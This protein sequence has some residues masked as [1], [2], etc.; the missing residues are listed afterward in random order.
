[1]NINERYVHMT[2]IKIEVEEKIAGKNRKYKRKILYL[3][4]DYC[5]NE[6]TCPENTKIR[7]LKK[8]NHFCSKSCSTNSLKNGLLRNK[9]E[10]TLINK[11][12][13]KGYVTAFDFQDKS[14]KSCIDKYGV[15]HGMKV[16]KIKNKLKQVC[17]EKYGK[18]TF[19]GSD[20]WRSKVD[21]K[22]IARKAWLT[23]IKNGSCSKS[24]TEEKLYQLLC[25][26]FGVDDVVRQVYI[27]RQWIDFYIKSLDLYLQL[28]GVYWHGLNRNISEIKNSS[29]RQDKKIYQNYVRDQKLNSYMKSKGLKMIRITDEL[30]N[31]SCK[32]DIINLLGGK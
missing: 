16:E 2:I 14:K 28:D 17:L 32:Q 31:K 19:L 21:H 10:N 22:D 8:E 15:D 5:S 6:Y 13:V 3:K 4:C 29:V 24:Y 7:A 30:F 23:K 26:I 12:G 11:Y 27:I 18:E 1:M 20:I 25:D 9:V